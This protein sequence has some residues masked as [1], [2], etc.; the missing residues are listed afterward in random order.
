[1]IIAAISTLALFMASLTPA[2]AAP[3]HTADQASGIAITQPTPQQ[4]E[5]ALAKLG[6]AKSTDPVGF[7]QRMRMLQNAD[8]LNRFLFADARF[9]GRQ[10]Q[11]FVAASMPT[12][13]LQGLIE[14][15]DAGMLKF[16]FVKN[17]NGQ[18]AAKVSKGHPRPLIGGGLGTTS[19]RPAGLDSLP[20]CPSAWAAFW[21]WYANTTLVCEALGFFGPWTA[22]GCYLALALGGMVIDFNMSC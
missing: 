22:A 14:M 2:S 7:G 1:M 21:A 16:E 17:S 12:D 11:E 19:I 18:P 6:A 4:R 20:Q 13:A 3:P 8:A 9:D 5:A 10:Q 15:T